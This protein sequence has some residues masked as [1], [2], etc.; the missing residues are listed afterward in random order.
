MAS[1]A[2][3]QRPLVTVVPPPWAADHAAAAATA[4]SSSSQGVP[5]EGP[6]T[7]PQEPL[8]I[9]CDTQPS[10]LFTAAFGTY[11]L[12]VIWL[13]EA[14][15]YGVHVIFRPEPWNAVSVIT[16][17]A[18]WAVQLISLARC[19]LTDPGG[20]S[21]EWEAQARA[22]SVPASTCK[23]SGHLL[24]PRARYVRRAGRVIVGFDHWCHWL[25]T[26]IGFRN[27]K[28]FILFVLY[29]AAFCTMGAAH[30]WAELLVLAPPRL[31]HSPWGWAEWFEHD[32]LGTRS[33][34]ALDWLYA[35]LA[36]ADGAGCGLYARAVLATCAINPAGALL[37]GAMGFNQVLMVILNRTTLDAEQTRYDVGPRANWE[38]VFGQR[39]H[40]W[41][42][43]L[44]GAGPG[45]NGVSWPLNPK[46]TAG[47]PGG[48]RAPPAPDAVRALWGRVLWVPLWAAQHG[49]SR[50]PITVEAL[51]TH[52]PRRPHAR[53]RRPAGPQNRA[54]LQPSSVSQAPPKTLA[55]L[56]L[57]PPRQRSNGSTGSAAAASS[58]AWCGRRCGS[59][60]WR[61][62]TSDIRTSHES[63]VR[64]RVGV[65]VP[66]GMSLQGTPSSRRSPRRRPTPWVRRKQG[67]EL[68][69]EHECMRMRELISSLASLFL[70]F[71][72]SSLL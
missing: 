56:C 33:R 60:C 17:Y 24:P 55:S 46:V 3:K 34:V 5:D 58:S 61:A 11:L 32:G 53:A 62:P 68:R 64:A 59:A 36:R 13:I 26:P 57:P 67:R 69:R 18:L 47:M 27:R 31:G 42:L 28:F 41:P 40:L 1:I 16:G 7:G 29:S 23:R 25:G 54:A 4:A 48:T 39:P 35:L 43:P 65:L 50:R 22:G 30:S 19:Q 15:N 10:Q 8:A 51:A 45:G 37:L 44:Y 2:P 63:T 66:S 70:V 38:Q 6:Y 52:N 72:N 21:S 71:G 9:R 49:Q 12:S 20:V 14:L